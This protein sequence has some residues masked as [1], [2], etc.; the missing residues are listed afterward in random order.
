MR[1]SGQVPRTQQRVVRTQI[2]S[3]DSQG[4]GCS[5]DVRFIKT[6]GSPS[7]DFKPET[8]FILALQYTVHFSVLGQLPAGLDLVP[9]PRTGSTF[10]YRTAHASLAPL[11]RHSSPRSSIRPTTLPLNSFWLACTVA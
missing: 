6:L 2:V 1:P 8:T 10:W 11:R 7:P 9:T 4:Y 5:G 3:P